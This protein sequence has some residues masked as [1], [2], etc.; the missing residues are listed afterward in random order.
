[1]PRNIMFPSITHLFVPVRMGRATLVV[2]A[3]VSFSLLVAGC[4][5][6]G[7]GGSS[8]DCAKS[9][10]AG[11]AKLSHDDINTD[12][13]VEAIE[14]D[15]AGDFRLRRKRLTASRA[16]DI[17]FH[18]VNTGA[19]TEPGFDD[20][21]QRIT[22]RLAFQAWEEVAN[23]RFREVDRAD[24]AYM[25][26]GFGTGT[27]C[28]LYDIA[29]A[30]C[31][32]RKELTSGKI[33]HCYYPDTG[34][35]AGDCHFNDDLTF[36]GAHSTGEFS[37]RLLDAAIHEIGHALGL[38]HSLC[39]AAIMTAAYNPKLRAPLLHPDDVAGIQ[40]LYGSPDLKTAPQGKFRDPT[41]PS[42]LDMAIEPEQD[43]DDSD[44]DGVPTSLEVFRIGSDPD[45]PDT[46]G[47]GLPDSEVFQGLDPRVADTDGDGISDFDEFT[48]G[49][50]PLTPDRG[51]DPETAGRVAGFYNGM[52]AGMEPVPLGGGPNLQVMEDDGR[53]LSFVVKPDGTATG[54]VSLLQYGFV[55]DVGLF[56]GVDESGEIRLVSF[57]YFWLLT[58]VF[59]ETGLTS[60]AGTF[61]ADKTVVAT[62]TAIL[63]ETRAVP[64][65]CLDTCR[66]AFNGECEDGRPGAIRATCDLGSDCFDC[67]FAVPPN[68]CLNSCG[69]PYVFNGECNDGRLGSANAICPPGTD[70]CDCEGVCPFEVPPRPF[71]R[72]P[73]G[74]SCW[75][76]NEDGIADLDTEDSNGDGMVNVLDCR[77]TPGSPG[78][79]GDE[80]PSGPEGPPGEE[81]P[82]GTD[83][84]QGDQGPA[85]PG[86][87][88]GD[89]GPDG[90]EGPE[91][92]E[93]PQGEPGEPG[94]SGEPGNGDCPVLCHRGRTMTVSESAV[95]A[96]LAHGDTCGPCE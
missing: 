79:D 65:D 9:K 29:D 76:L 15:E 56:G 70:C 16:A 19:N 71:P 42:F 7:G 46:D 43:D 57:D 96:H 80:G 30:D 72:Q 58:G 26:M 92:P 12:A 55:M 66:T 17:T 62:W 10:D 13:L 44:G 21:A 49:S 8:D 31:N 27:H 14:D 73:T 51:F 85:G 45:N 4:S 24:D 33:A 40:A 59:D 88:Q 95:R 22:I 53:S 68:A 3:G 38:D 25:I 47:D 5:S 67:V 37:P 78:P 36:T 50:D 75:D 64:K 60:V 11:V 32:F 61:A 39:A 69:P 48:D 87:P 63:D 91:G 81:G 84:S 90:P 82:E 18:V 94:D 34:D 86:G 1:M 6:G 74:I 77:G 41:P 28:E 83:G 93:G 2:L 20:S 23:V 89:P 54:V 35:R 52:I